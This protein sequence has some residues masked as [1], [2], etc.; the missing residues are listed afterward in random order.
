MKQYPMPEGKC[1]RFNKLIRSEPVQQASIL[2]IEEVPWD[3][4]SHQFGVLP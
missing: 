1:G 2:M 3:P 4:T